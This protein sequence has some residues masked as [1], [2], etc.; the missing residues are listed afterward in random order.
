MILLYTFVYSSIGTLPVHIPL[1]EYAV[2]FIVLYTTLNS[3][4]SFCASARDGMLIASCNV[5]LI[6]SLNGISICL[7]NGESVDSGNR[8]NS[9]SLGLHSTFGCVMYDANISLVGTPDEYTGPLVGK[10]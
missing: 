5:P 2:R 3:S 9:R 10:N 6:A 7:L 1:L 8:M 4:S